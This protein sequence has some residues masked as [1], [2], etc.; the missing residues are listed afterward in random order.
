LG[1]TNRNF[2]SASEARDWQPTLARASGRNRFSPRSA[3][4]AAEI[5][6]RRRSIRARGVLLRD[7]PEVLRLPGRLLRFG[8]LL[9][10]L[11]GQHADLLRHLLSGLPILLSRSRAAR[12]ANGKQRRRNS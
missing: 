9:H 1:S 7:D 5:L 12:R 8:L 2:K 6:P 4:C 10:D 11:A 3:S